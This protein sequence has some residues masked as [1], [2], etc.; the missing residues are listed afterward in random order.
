MMAAAAPLEFWFDFASSY[1]Y[2]SAMRI[3]DEAARRNVAVV[4]KPF[5]L[6]PIFV[7]MGLAA[8]PFTLYPAKG[9]YM[10]RDLDRICRSRA[11]PFHPPDTLPARSVLANRTGLVALRE[12]WGVEFCKALFTAEFGEG[13]NIDDRAVL[14]AVL[15]AFASKPDA[16]L[17]LAE[18]EDTKRLLRERTAEAERRGL[19]GAPSFVT[20]DGELFW[21][22]DRLDS[23][24]DAMTA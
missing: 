21:G 5:L 19:F 23:A 16:V 9:A 2:L 18:D 17:N 10:L 12:S 24:L 6:G 7:K 13:R 3:C 15:G 11:L 22:D 4:W 20:P 8:S 1:S 14:R